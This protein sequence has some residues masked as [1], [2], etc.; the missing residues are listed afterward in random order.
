MP[1]SPA[2]YQPRRPYHFQ[3]YQCVEDDFETLKQLY[4]E[5]FAHEYGF[6]RLLITF[7]FPP[8]LAPPLA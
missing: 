3:D 6:F 4:D 2:I 1:A 5:R 7:I 8:I